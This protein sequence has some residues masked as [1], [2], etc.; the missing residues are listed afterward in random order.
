[1]SINRF[2]MSGDPNNRFRLCMTIYGGFRGIL[3]MEG[4]LHFT[5]TGVYNTRVV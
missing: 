3:W 5:A 4:A 1:M 2:K